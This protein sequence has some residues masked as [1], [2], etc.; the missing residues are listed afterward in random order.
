M[1]AQ[2]TGLID[3]CRCRDRSGA[4]NQGIGRSVPQADEG[5]ASP[6]AP[7]PKTKS[8]TVR[9]SCTSSWAACASRLS[10][11]PSIPPSRPFDA[12]VAGVISPGVALLLCRDRSLHRVAETGL[13]SAI[14]GVAWVKTEVHVIV[15]IT[16]VVASGAVPEYVYT[17]LRGRFAMPRF[18]AILAGLPAL[19]GIQLHLLVGA[20]SIHLPFDPGLVEVGQILIKPNWL[21]RTLAIAPRSAMMIF[22]AGLYRLE[23][24]RAGVTSRSARASLKYGIPHGARFFRPPDGANSLDDLLEAGSQPRSAMFFTSGPCTRCYARVSHNSL[25]RGGAVR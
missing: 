17:F 13:S 1:G 14:I 7:S 3:G 2:P 12:A 6:R 9:K 25:A 8:P 5:L 16:D 22:G 23:I 15:G 10:S 21:S 18:I 20:G 24:R 11:R 4:K 19:L